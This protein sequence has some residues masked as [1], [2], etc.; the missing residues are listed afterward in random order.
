M[1]E[2][3]KLLVE[4]SSPWQEFV[5]S[6]R[7]AIG[8][9][10][11]RLAGEAQTGLFPIRGLLLSWGVEAIFLTLLIIIPAKLAS[12]RPY[13]PPA[14]PKYDVIYFSADELPNI[15]DRGGAQAGKSGHAGGKEAHH[16][17]QTIR[18]ARGNSAVEKVVDA[19]DLKL[20]VSSAPV[21]NLLAFKSVPGPPPAE[22]LKSSRTAPDLTKNSIVAPP[23]EVSRERNRI[24]G[25]NSNVIAPPPTN[26]AQEKNRQ[27]MG[28]STTIVA[29]APQDVPRDQSRSLVPMNSRII[30]PS[31]DD[32]QR[33]LPPMRGSASAAA[34][35]VPPPVSAPQ[36]DTS[37]TSRLS[38]PAAGVVA[39]PPSQLTRDA[40]VSGASLVDPKVV[41][42]PAEI[43]GRS[44]DKSALQGLVGANQVVPPP[45]SVTGGASM[46]GGGRGHND[47]AG[48]FGAA[49]A[50]GDIVPPPP[51]VTG[52]TSG[53]GRV[54]GNPQGTLGGGLS[55]NSVV[56]PPPSL[57]DAAGLPGRG[58]GSRGSG[59]G[60]PLDS[61][62]V[63]APA[64]R[65]GVSG[66]KGV[67]VSSQPGSVQGV[68]SNGTPGALAMSPGGRDKSGIGGS[69][70]GTGIGHGAGPGSGLSG[71]GSGAAKE[72][73]GRGSDPNARGG[74]SPYSGPGGSGSGTNGQPPI[75]GAS[76]AGGTTTASTITLPSFGSG[77]PD[78]GAM[79]GGPGAAKSR[80]G[81][82]VSVFG[83][84]RSGGAF[85]RYG[86]LP[87]DNY[88]IY[89]PTT[90]GTAVMQYADPASAGR[91]YAEKLI[92][93][94]PLRVTLPAGLSP[95]RLV[96][97][98]V[99]GRTG[100]LSNIRVIE[101]GPQPM[102]S[103]VV[104][105]L[106]TWKFTPA[107]HGNQPVEVNAFLGFNIDTR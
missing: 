48:G 38:L 12:M 76:V 70:G 41:P 68:P 102:T 50:G 25:L 92:D 52:D 95:S 107:L 51:S 58:T 57:N 33:D 7:P 17:S 79:P 30:Q 29:P 90:L 94:D 65:G 60:G 69:G 86:Q 77:E 53:S 71:E 106:Y 43:G 84:S 45:P 47:K 13:L 74:I 72:G 36:R 96:V 1:N 62:S 2:G 59:L 89:I 42:P 10:P 23:P 22:G 9:S 91:P 27:M 64:T 26:V 81:L 15:Q 11:A 85:N 100:T 67:V 44:Q 104:A 78:P 31:P 56:P 32:V 82:G 8:R 37:Q 66:G 35:V 80:R 98:C 54:R 99:L 83:T 61:G 16:R 3:P 40:R 63:L 6:I 24:E 73:T 5:T 49:L 28:L 75:P 21:A 97:A 20:P 14:P 101:A 88:T 34:V 46:T 55:A 39:P 103:K 19:P 4:W 93:P 105:A 87:G 18:V